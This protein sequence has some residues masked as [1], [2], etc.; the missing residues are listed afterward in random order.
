MLKD[1]NVLP[2]NFSD[3]FVV[4]SQS[5]PNTGD[6]YHQYW[7]MGQNSCAPPFLRKERCDDREDIQVPFYE[8]EVPQIGELLSLLYFSH[9]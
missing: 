6:P 2:A 5:Y 1:K 7:G 8:E 3:I 4:F 9:L